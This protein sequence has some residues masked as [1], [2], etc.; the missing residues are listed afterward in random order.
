MRN[1]VVLTLMLA[2]SIASAQ[3][4]NSASSDTL[5]ARVQAALRSSQI[6]NAEQIEVEAKGDAVQLSGFVASA[7]EQEKALKSARAVRG[8]ATVRNDLV[9]RESEPSAEQARDDTVIAARVRKQIATKVAEGAPDINVNV[10]DGVV[11]L[12]GYV[13][14]AGVKTRAADVASTVNGVQDVLNDIALKP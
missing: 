11:Q 8:V 5:A 6:G 14:D 10:N 4:S 13:A 3:V 1:V 12:S 9:V 2:A 7:A